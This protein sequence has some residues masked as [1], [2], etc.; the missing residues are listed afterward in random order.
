MLI[1]NFCTHDKNQFASGGFKESYIFT[2]LIIFWTPHH[3]YLPHSRI[4]TE[5]QKRFLDLVLVSAH[6]WLNFSQY[7]RQKKKTDWLAS[8]RKR[9]LFP[10]SHW[11]SARLFGQVK[12][13]TQ[14]HLFFPWWLWFWYQLSYFSQKPAAFLPQTVSLLKR[15]WTEL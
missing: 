5:V 3:K 12:W 6:R 7:F 15:N 13:Q 4:L 9:S 11:H 2:F 8:Q 14:C 1:F 10:S